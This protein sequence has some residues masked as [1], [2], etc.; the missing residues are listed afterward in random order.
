M[1]TNDFSTSDQS[2]DELQTE[3]NHAGQPALDW[4]HEIHYHQLKSSHHPI[5]FIRNSFHIIGGQQPTSCNVEV[6]KNEKFLE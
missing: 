6:E 1:Y 2:D 5:Q 3:T 4:C